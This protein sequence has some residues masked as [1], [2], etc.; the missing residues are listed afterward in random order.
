[1]LVHRI[2][3]IL[4][5]VALVFAPLAIQSGAAMAMAP[6]DHHGQMAGA[7]HC[8]TKPEPNAGH[9]APDNDCCVAMC[10]ATAVIP[11][12]LAVPPQFAALVLSPS[13]APVGHG[14]LAEL[15]TPPPRF[16]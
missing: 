12:G 5:A 11:T 2:F 3:A 1:M 8:G 14:F 4:I 13:P 6:A 15:P 16:S 7:D 10:V 9:K